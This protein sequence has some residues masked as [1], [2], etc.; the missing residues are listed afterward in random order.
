MQEQA[1]NL[2]TVILNIIKLKNRKNAL[3]GELD[4]INKQIEQQTSFLERVVLEEQLVVN[5][6]PASE[7]PE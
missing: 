1:I 5:Q 2:K 4:I 6:P 3:E 7:K